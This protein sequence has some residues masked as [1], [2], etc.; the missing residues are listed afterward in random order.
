MAD[1]RRR[2]ARADRRASKIRTPAAVLRGA[3][4]RAVP[5]H[6]GEGLA[7]AG[8]RRRGADPRTPTLSRSETGTDAQPAKSI[9][10]RGARQHNLK[11][12]DVDIPRDRITVCCG[13]SGSGKSSLAMDTIYAEGQRRYVE[14]LSAYARQ[15]VGQMQKPK[16]DHIEGLSPAI[17]IEQKHSGQ[18][19]AEHR[20]HGD[21]D[22]RLPADPPVAARAAAIARP[23]TCPSAPQSADEVIEKI[24]AHPAGTKL[25]LMAPLEIHVG[26][27]YETLWEQSRARRATSAFASTARPIRSTSRRRSTAGASTSVEVVIDRVTVRPDARSRHRRQRR[28]RPGPGPRRARAWPIPATTCPSR[29]GRAKRHSQHFAC[30]RCGR[31]FE[32]LSPHHFSFNSPLGW[33]PA[34][35]GL[36]VQTG[37]NPAAL[38]A[39]SEAHAGPGRR[40]ALAG[41]RQPAVRARCSEAFAARHRRAPGRPLRAARRPPSPADLARHRRAVVRRAE[42]DARLKAGQRRKRRARTLS[43]SGRRFRFQYKGLYPALEEAS[44]VSPGFRIQAGTPGRRS[45]VLG[46]RRQPAPRRC[47]GRAAPRPHDRRTLPHAAGP[48]ARRSSPSWKPDARRAED[49]RRGAPRDPQPRAIPRRRGAGVSDARPAGPDAL[50]RRD[51]ADPAG[52]P[53]RQRAVRRALRARR[54]DHRPAPAR[55]PPAARRPAR[56]SAT[57]ATRCWWSSTTAR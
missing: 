47:R 33:C 55:Q 10:V 38:A 3:G 37:T 45:R 15:F 28:E 19:A 41:A 50:R 4:R 18:H 52:R 31:S 24:M 30:D 32:P 39:R 25:Y 2:H 23:A 48:A 14:S 1:R 36:G 57:W 46:L 9:K 35:E 12:I 11:G 49:R 7:G 51:A 29:T 20:G 26:E 54:A 43:L 16:L 27:R 40:G 13:P 21:R 17:A 22:L 6:P 56:S 8:R 5:S 34:C 44:R 42:A 53:G